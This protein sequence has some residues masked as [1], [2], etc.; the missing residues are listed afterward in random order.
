MTIPT[1]LTLLRIVLT[2]VIIGLLFLPGWGAKAAACVGFLIASFTDWIDGYLARRWQQTSPLGA[3]L[4]PIADKI[5]ILGLL[6]VFVQ[7][8]LIPAWMVLLIALREVVITGVRLYAAKRHLVLPAATEGKH[9]TVVQLLAVLM[10]FAVLMAREGVQSGRVAV[11][12]LARLQGLMLLSL[13]VAVVLTVC[14]GAG[15][16]WRHRAVLRDVIAKG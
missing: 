9:K 14:S 2:F 1:K 11:G 6:L 12:T 4:D 7:L 13:W 8:G 5:L 10:M 3:L 15:F 16:F